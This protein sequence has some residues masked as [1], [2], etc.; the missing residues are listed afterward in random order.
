MACLDGAMEW[1]PNGQGGTA[2]D[3]R[4]GRGVSMLMWVGRGTAR[5]CRGCVGVAGVIGFI[6][7]TRLR[8]VVFGGF[9]GGDGVA[10][11]RVGRGV[12]ASSGAA[13][14]RLHSPGE[15]WAW[16]WGASWILSEK[17]TGHVHRQCP[18]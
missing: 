8:V 15:L 12:A 4:P 13:V 1:G 11:V 10:G 7:G 6:L 3:H 14:V 5:M 17:I 18:T 9:V 16:A 2:W